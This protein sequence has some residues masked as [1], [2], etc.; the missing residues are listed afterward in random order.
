MIV[1][2][3]TIDST[4]NIRC[5]ALAYAVRVA[6]APSGRGEGEHAIEGDPLL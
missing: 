6:R 4:H 1:I 3:T 5:W 2:I